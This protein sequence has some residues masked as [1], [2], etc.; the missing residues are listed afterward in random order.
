M[1]NEEMKV[2]VISGGRGQDASYL[3]EFLLEKDYKV[4]AFERRISNPDFSNIKDIMNHPNFELVC[5]DV[6]DMASV[7]NIMSKY[8]PD[9]FYNL[10]GQSFVAASWD[11]PLETSN[12]NYNGVGNCLEAIRICSPKTKFLQ[13]STSEV[14][15][16]VQN[17][18][19]DEDTP[20]RPRS[21]YAASKHAAEGLIK[22][23]RDSYGLFACYSRAFNHESKRRGQEFVTRKITKWIGDAWKIVDGKV[24]DYFKEGFPGDCSK[25]SGMLS[26]SAGFKRA[27]VEGDIEPLRLGNLE[28]RRDWSHAKD[29]VRG[30]WLMMQ[31]DKPDDYVLASGT[32]R[33][34]KEFLTDAFGIAGIGKWDVFVVVDEKF[35]RPADVNLLCG[36]ASKAK[37]KLDWEPQIS[38]TDMVKEMVNHDMDS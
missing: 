14:Y 4:V 30:M 21:P 11:E 22:T 9:E 29:I 27:L 19:Q 13:A 38:F 12:V 31:E 25:R 10:A 7:C 17:D 16:D 26:Y 8:Q 28:A 24:S 37:E 33:S 5:G 34:I 20:A 35:F 6:T 3:A 15:G 2:A 18:K 36:D 1:M 32:T 23:Y